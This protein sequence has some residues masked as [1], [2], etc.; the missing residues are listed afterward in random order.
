MYVYDLLKSMEYVRDEIGKKNILKKYITFC[1]QLRQTHIDNQPV[2]IEPSLNDLLSTINTL[3]FSSFTSGMENILKQYD[4]FM[5]VGTEAVEQI[6][7][8]KDSSSFN[9]QKAV[10][11]I[12]SMRDKLSELIQTANGYLGL[13]KNLDLEKEYDL[14]DNQAVMQVSFSDVMP[15]DNVK[16]LSL[17]IK[18]CQIIFDKYGSLNRCSASDI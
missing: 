3:D 12:D 8:I 7:S 16:E 5:L 18:D 10:T 1:Q 2:D 15:I 9:P 4:F 6:S 17:W 13:L 11:D 14:E